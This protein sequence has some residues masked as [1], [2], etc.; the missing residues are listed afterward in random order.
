MHTKAWSVDVYLLD[1]DGTTRAEAVLRSRAGTEL[2]RVATAYQSSA[3]RDAPEVGDEL[4]ACRALRDLAHSL[5]AATVVDVRLSDAAAGKPAA[6]G[7][8]ASTDHV[9]T[10][11]AVSMSSSRWGSP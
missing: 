6:C 8:R 10:G 5:L 7:A 11:E 1:D 4:A 2:W 3:D 9:G